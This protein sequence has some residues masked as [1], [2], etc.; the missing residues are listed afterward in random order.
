MIRKL[1]YKVPGGKL[2]RVAIDS[3]GDGESPIASSVRVAGDF[4]A[5]PEEAFE[6]AEAE[7]SGL[8]MSELRAASFR[9]F[10]RPDLRLFGASPEDISIAIGSAAGAACGPARAGSSGPQPEPL[11]PAG[12]KEAL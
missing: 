9:A 8:P 5:H 2:L 12:S 3:G 6:A 4:F 7:L 10:S 1:D 11:G